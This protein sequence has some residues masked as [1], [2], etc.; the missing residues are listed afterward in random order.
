MRVDICRELIMSSMLPSPHRSALAF[1]AAMI[2]L[3]GCGSKE[4]PAAVQ[5]PVASG[6]TETVSTADEYYSEDCHYRLAFPIG[7]QVTT[8]ESP[9]GVADG[10]RFEI[11]AGDGPLQGRVSGVAS[12]TPSYVDVPTGEQCDRSIEELGMYR[13]RASAPAHAPPFVVTY[14]LVKPGWYVFSGT[15]GNEIIYEKGLHY[16]NSALLRVYYPASKKEVFNPLVARLANS[17]SE[18]VVV[19]AKAGVMV[20]VEE[21]QAGLLFLNDVYGDDDNLHTTCSVD[22]KDRGQ[23]SSLQEGQTVTVGG[24]PR[25]VNVRAKTELMSAV[26]HRRLEHCVL[27]TGR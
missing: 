2:L 6:P 21:D 11:R 3:A 25:L 4:K 9:A 23:F 18:Y 15:R 16:A 10:V 27:R 19:T 1:V 5:Q 7:T 8:Q 14:R 12:G 24:Q 17:F 22:A 20:G 26:F 13:D